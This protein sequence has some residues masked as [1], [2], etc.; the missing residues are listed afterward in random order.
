MCWLTNEFNPDI[1]RLTDK[2]SYFLLLHV[3]LPP[4]MG[5]AYETSQYIYEKS[6]FPAHLNTSTHRAP[7]LFEIH[8]K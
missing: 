8:H 6:T 1:H 3:W 5:G 7:Q 2:F 4:R